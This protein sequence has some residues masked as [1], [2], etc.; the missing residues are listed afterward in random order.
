MIKKNASAA[1][2][3]DWFNTTEQFVQNAKL[4]APE[5]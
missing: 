4:A 1:D 5:S 3:N 2:S